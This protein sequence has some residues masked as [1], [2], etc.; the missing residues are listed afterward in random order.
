MHHFT[1]VS[2][3]M[4]RDDCNQFDKHFCVFHYLFKTNQGDL[5][6]TVQKFWK[7]NIQWN[8]LLRKENLLYASIKR[9]S[10][11][12]LQQRKVG[13]ARFSFHICR[14]IK[15]IMSHDSLLF[16]KNNNQWI[17]LELSIKTWSKQM[18]SFDYLWNINNKE[19]RKMSVNFTNN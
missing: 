5:S 1:L 17:L 16:L 19:K 15:E 6:F 12:C 8:L 4:I 3:K 18:N 9:G 14:Y 13:A 2:C 7:S 11:D 10:K